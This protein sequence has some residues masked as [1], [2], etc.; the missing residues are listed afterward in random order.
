VQ[1]S[2]KAWG[3]SPAWAKVLITLAA[4]AVVGALSAGAYELTL[5]R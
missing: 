1:R 4:V 5:G 3:R 2:R